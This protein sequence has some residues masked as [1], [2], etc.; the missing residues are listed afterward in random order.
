M[1]SSRGVG[2]TRCVMVGSLR[3]CGFRMR[4]W[5]GNVGELCSANHSRKMVDMLQSL[6][7][8]L[9]EQLVTPPSADAL[10]TEVPHILYAQCISKRLWL[11]PT[12]L[13]RALPRS[14]SPPVVGYACF[15][16][17]WKRLPCAD[18]PRPQNQA[19][20]GQ[21]ERIG[22]EYCWYLLVLPHCVDTFLSPVSV[23]TPIM[24]EEI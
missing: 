24:Y 3:R 23:N 15:G 19:S 18:S 16:S 5:N 22:F 7:S 21:A 9:P 8:H 17:E 14:S 10:D 13:Y 11:Q 2:Q 20:A 12:S 6:V 4:S 1:L